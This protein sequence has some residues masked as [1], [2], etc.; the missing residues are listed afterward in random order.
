MRDEQL[1]REVDFLRKIENVLIRLGK[2]K[3]RRQAA[4]MITERIMQ[5]TNGCPEI[6]RKCFEAFLRA[7]A[8]VSV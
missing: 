1:D 5:W 3:K 7:N 4:V 8:N 6:A 2:C